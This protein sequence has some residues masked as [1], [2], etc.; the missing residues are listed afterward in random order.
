[1]SALQVHA[2]I[3]SVLSQFNRCYKVV[4]GL[5]PQIQIQCQAQQVSA[6]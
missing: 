1:M 2:D 4:V 3:T 6:Q 5:D